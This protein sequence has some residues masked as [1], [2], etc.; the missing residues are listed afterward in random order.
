MSAVASP[1]ARARR[2]ASGSSTARVARASRGP[3]PL[4][5]CSSVEQLAL[6]GVGES[7]ERQRVLPDHQRGGQPRLLPP[8]QPGERRRAWRAPPGPTPP[9]STTAWS[10]PISSTSPRTAA[11]TTPP[12]LVPCPT[13]REPVR[14][15]A[16][17]RTTRHERASRY[18]L[19]RECVRSGPRS[20]AGRRRCPSWLVMGPARAVA[21]TDEARAHRRHPRPQA[22]PRPAGAGLGARSRPPTSSSTRATG[23]TR[24]SWTRWRTRRAGSSAC[25]GNNDGPALRARLP[26]VADVELD[27][28][29]V[30]VVHETGPGDRP[31]AALRGP[32]PGPRRARLRPQPHPVGHR[33][34]RRPAAAQ[35]GLAHRPAAPAAT[36]PT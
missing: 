16:R 33:R 5:V 25:Y 4:T 6:L 8:A 1:S 12:P 28:L 18:E 36:P 13:G 34:T 26:E 22:G 20:R 10:S 17:A 11:I 32:L 14:P 15:C 3:T 23:S 7:E 9:T 31:R 27:G 24:R 2:S 19:A 30:G 21:W 29:R 35:P